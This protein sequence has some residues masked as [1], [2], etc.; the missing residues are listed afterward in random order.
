MGQGESEAEGVAFW[1]NGDAVYQAEIDAMMATLTESMAQLGLDTS[2]R[3]FLR[4]SRAWRSSK[5]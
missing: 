5:S 4:P 2:M 1:V 3:R